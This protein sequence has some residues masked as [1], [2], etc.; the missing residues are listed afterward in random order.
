M[1]SHRINSLPNSENAII[2]DSKLK[3]YALNPESD[4]GRHK[5]RV[6]QSALGFNLTNWQLLKQSILENL[7]HQA[8]QVKGETAFGKKYTVELH[9]TGPNRNT[10]PVLTVWQFDRQPDGTL[11]DMP[12]LVTLYVTD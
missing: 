9:L 1:D 3:E 2:E 11:S 5:A 6:F 7:P 12:R 4:A 8:A 10:V